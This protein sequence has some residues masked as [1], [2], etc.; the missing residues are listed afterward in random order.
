MHELAHHIQFTEHHKTGN[1][2][3]TKLFYAILDDLADKAEALGLYK[4]DSDSEVK[5]LIEDA[6]AISAEIAALQRKLG[7][8]LNNLQNA[9]MKSGVRYEDVVKRKV[10]LSVRQ[11]KKLKKITALEVPEDIGYEMQDAIAGAKNEEQRESMLIAAADGKSV[12][13]VKQAG[14]VKKAK[15]E[16]NNTEALLKEKARIE[17]TIANL[18]IRLKDILNRIKNLGGGG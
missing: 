16:E 7:A 8:V 6:A 1:R 18:K 13:Q 12:D 14:F 15:P 11:E 17:K 9:C 10:K 3:H 5:A 4:Y 2:S